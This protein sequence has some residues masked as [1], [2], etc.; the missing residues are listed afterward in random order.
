MGRGYKVVLLGL[1]AHTM[2][3]YE[4]DGMVRSRFFVNV[5][6]L[7]NLC[8]FH[9]EVSPLLSFVCE[10]SMTLCWVFQVQANTRKMA[11]LVVTCSLLSA[12][13]S[14]LLSVLMTGTLLT[15]LVL[16]IDASWRHVG[17]LPR[18]PRT[19][20]GNWLG[21]MFLKFPTGSIEDGSA[22]TW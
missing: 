1:E 9:R 17:A 21:G 5:A 18:F 4:I 22:V 15:S 16:W 11:S 3:V 10:V 12:P 7:S 2:V 8:L 14:S 19:Q 20:L 13:G 6:K